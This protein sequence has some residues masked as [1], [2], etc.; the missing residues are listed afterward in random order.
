MWIRLRRDAVIF[1]YYFFF[2]LGGG[3]GGGGGACNC[4]E[5]VAAGWCTSK[6]LRLDQTI[7]NLTSGDLGVI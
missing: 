6:G 2:F 1:F 5:W 3:E 7:R 4:M